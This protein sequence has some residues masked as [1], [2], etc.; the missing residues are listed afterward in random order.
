MLPVRAVRP[1]IP[2]IGNVHIGSAMAGAMPLGVAVGSAMATK[3]M[4]P[5]PIMATAME[6]GALLPGG[7][8][9]DARLI[10]MVDRDA[11]IGATMV[12]PYR[13]RRGEGPNRS[14]W[15]SVRASGTRAASRTARHA[16]EVSS[17]ASHAPFGL[18]PCRI[19]PCLPAFWCSF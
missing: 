9:E 1:L 4:T 18:F 11:I 10:D 6:T 13:T 8:I 19:T 16:G 7:I 5:A 3:V 15:G 17:T 14:A 2:H 12:V